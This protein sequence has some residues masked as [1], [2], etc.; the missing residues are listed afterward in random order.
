MRSCDTDESRVA[1]LKMKR[2]LS[3]DFIREVGLAN[4][5]C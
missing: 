5:K 4:A 3:F 1:G 2:L